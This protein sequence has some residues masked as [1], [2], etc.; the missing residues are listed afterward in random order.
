MLQFIVFTS[1]FTCLNAR[2]QTGS[3]LVH[4]PDRN[5]DVA[6]FEKGGIFHR[7]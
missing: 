4:L 6:L 7:I 1:I 5:P 3:A 2:I